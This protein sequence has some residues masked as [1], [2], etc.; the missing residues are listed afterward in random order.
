MDFNPDA[1]HLYW[2][3]MDDIEATHNGVGAQQH[4]LLH[5]GF[6]TRRLEDGLLLLGRIY[7]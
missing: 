6:V 2:T 4:A 7:V 3:C 5:A 1:S